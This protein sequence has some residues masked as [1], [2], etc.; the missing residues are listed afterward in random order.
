MAPISLCVRG[1]GESP[2][3][4]LFAPFHW[5]RIWSGWSDLE[6]PFIPSAHTVRNLSNPDYFPHGVSSGSS[7][8]RTASGTPEMT[9]SALTFN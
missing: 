3:W 1:G 9:F 5:G 7:V 2:P 8:C 4:Q 6:W